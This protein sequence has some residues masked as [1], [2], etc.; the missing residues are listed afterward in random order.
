[1]CSLSTSEQ[2]IAAFCLPPFPFAVLTLFSSLLLF[3]SLLL[4]PPCHI[5][6]NEV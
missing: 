3:V 4:V 1:M 5:V 6:Y 2:L